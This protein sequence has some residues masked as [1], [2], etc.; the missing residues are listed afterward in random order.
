[1]PQWQYVDKWF[2]A[3]FEY[4]DNLPAIYIVANGKSL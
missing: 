2:Q 3:S 4:V 1:M